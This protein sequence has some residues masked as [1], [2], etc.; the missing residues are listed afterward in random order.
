VPR[1]RVRLVRDSFAML[2]DV[3]GIRRAANAGCY[4]GPINTLRPSG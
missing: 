1:S 2:R 4:D 3:I